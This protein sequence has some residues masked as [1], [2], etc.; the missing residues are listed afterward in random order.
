MS[1]FTSADSFVTPARTETI[2][3]KGIFDLEGLYKMIIKW[4]Q[5]RSYEFHEK[6]YKHKPG[7]VGKQQ[8]MK[9]EA[10]QKWDEYIRFWFTLHI[11]VWDM[12]DV[13]VVKDNQTIKMI[14]GRIRIQIN[15]KIDRDYQGRWNKSKNIRRL[16]DFFDKY[17]IFKD[18]SSVWGDLMHYKLVKLQN[19]IKEY[20]GM[21][22][23]SKA[24]YHY[25]G[26]E[27]SG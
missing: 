10:W 12:L 24:F 16:R 6:I 15:G 7:D 11:H 26:P 21:T 19:E 18:M 23:P 27:Q 25:M 5:D 20:L 14:K 9:W 2:E 8:E 1:E 4:L 13:E 17:V 22:T 3:Y